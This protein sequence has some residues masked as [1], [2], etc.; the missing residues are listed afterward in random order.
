M[1][2][3]KSGH[4]INVTSD[5]ERIPFAGVSVYTGKQFVAVNIMY[6]HEVLFNFDRIN[7][8]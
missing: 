2:E 1:K 6:V 3:R 7:P 8:I 5:S 4:F